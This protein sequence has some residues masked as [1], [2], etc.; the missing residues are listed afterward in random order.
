MH[1]WENVLMAMYDIE[2]GVL[3]SNITVNIWEKVLMA[4]YGSDIS[5]MGKELLG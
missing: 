4:M 3:V 5:S 1:I 2:N